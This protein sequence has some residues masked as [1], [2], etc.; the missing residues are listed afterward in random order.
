MANDL[1]SDA[2]MAPNFTSVDDIAWFADPNRLALVSSLYAPGNVICWL[3]TVVACCITWT[4]NLKGR[5]ADSIDSNLIAALGYMAVAGAHQ[6][7][8]LH[9]YAA[10]QP[11]G[12]FVEEPTLQKKVVAIEASARVLEMAMACCVLLFVVAVRFSRLKR[13]LVVGVI[14]MFCLAAE[15][16]LFFKIRHTM[17]TSSSNCHLEDR[18]RCTLCRD[19]RYRMRRSCPP[20][21]CILGLLATFGVTRRHESRR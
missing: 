19:V 16:Y 2:T 9:G 11:F 20:R 3:L 12:H 13:A 5:K 18:L 15:V 7:T 8:Q 14:G 17:T 1:G 10:H 21:L 4:M 6:A